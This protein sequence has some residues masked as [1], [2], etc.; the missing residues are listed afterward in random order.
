MKQAIICLGLSTLAVAEHDGTKIP[1][2]ETQQNTFVSS[3]KYVKTGI[4]ALIVF[5]VVVVL[6]LLIGTFVIHYR[7]S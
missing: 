7:R 4:V 2:D 3:Q 1:H 6:A 5:V